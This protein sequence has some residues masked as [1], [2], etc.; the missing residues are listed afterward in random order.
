MAP[1]EVGDG[2][3]SREQRRSSAKMQH[4]PG[5]VPVPKDSIFEEA[6]RQRRLPALFPPEVEAG[7]LQACDRGP[8]AIYRRYRSAHLS[9]SA[10]N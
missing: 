4:D 8:G 7:I 3:E 6:E 10:L 1:G 9:G 5:L 2:R